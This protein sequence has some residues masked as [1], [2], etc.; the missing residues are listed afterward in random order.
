MTDYAIQKALNVIAGT[1]GLA[2]QAAANAAIGRVAAMPQD[3]GLIVAGPID[4]VQTTTNTM[5]VA[6]RN[7][8]VRITQGAGTISKIGLYVG[9]SSGNI[10][11]AV[12][13]NSGVGPA[14]VPTTRLATSGAVACPAGAAYAEV[15][16]GASVDVEPGYWFSLSVDNNTATFSGIQTSGSALQAGLF[17]YQAAAHPAPSSAASLSP[18]GRAFVLLGIA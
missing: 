7:Q 12:Y 5:G 9:T 11:V 8:Y 14:A 1:T 13:S 17:S 15:A 2:E 6:S 16:L 18:G 3:L 4:I 10:S